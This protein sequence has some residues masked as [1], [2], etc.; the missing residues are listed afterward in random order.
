MSDF[1]NVKEKYFDYVL[2]DGLWEFHRNYHV[3]RYLSNGKIKTGGIFGVLKD[4]ISIRKRYVTKF[5]RIYILWDS[6]GYKK[7]EKLKSYK[8][9][10]AKLKDSFFQQLKLLKELLTYLGIPQI[11]V[12]RIEAD[13][14]AHYFVTKKY[15]DKKILLFAKDSDWVKL[16]NKNVFMMSKMN[17]V[18]DK[19]SVDEKLGF[20]CRKILIFKSIVGDKKDNVFGVSYLN[21]KQLN[22]IINKAGSLTDTFKICNVLKKV[23]K[24]KKFKKISE[25][26]LEHEKLIKRNY[27][28]LNYVR[29]KDEEVNIDLGLNDFNLFE[30]LSKKL[31]LKSI[32]KMYKLYNKGGKI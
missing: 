1:L 31:K 18:Q 19:K 27:N 8:A 22:K 14:L 9:N 15:K 4:L 17:E 24:Y 25:K 3:M 6:T 12:K 7:K 11:T 16:L 2:V 5:R 28:L 20:D 26:I 30:K 10:R 21:R 32:I 23:E 29:I 13:D